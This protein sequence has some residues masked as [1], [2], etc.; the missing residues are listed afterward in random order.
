MVSLRH[1]RQALGRSK[2][3]RPARYPVA[4]RYPVEAYG[5][6]LHVLIAPTAGNNE[7]RELANGRKEHVRF[8][9]QATDMQS[10]ATTIGALNKPEA[11]PSA[12]SLEQTLTR[13]TTAGD[14]CGMG[15]GERLLAVV[16][17]FGGG[18]RTSTGRSD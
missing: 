14:S 15:D 18:R 16:L 8:E 3:R 6:G 5:T 17:R 13:Q 9:T 2:L 10:M 7:Y 1:R 11:S 4:D 12:A